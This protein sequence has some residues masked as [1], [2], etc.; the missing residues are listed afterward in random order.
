MGHFGLFGKFIVKAEDRDVL[1][2]LLLEAAE[3]LQA[4]KDCMVYH[5]SVSEEEPESVFVY[6]VWKDQQAHEASLSLEAVQVLIRRA[7]PLIKD[8]K[9]ISTL[10]IKGGKYN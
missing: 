7:K 1:V 10:E 9:R 3:A 6:E 8:M 2:D 5:V 4:L